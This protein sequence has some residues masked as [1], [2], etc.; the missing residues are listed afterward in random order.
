MNSRTRP[1]PR[2]GP[3]PYSPGPIRFPV[4]T[5]TGETVVVNSELVAEDGRRYRRSS[6]PLYV[7]PIEEDEG[8]GE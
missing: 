6:R 5:I 3:R 7:E 4:K 8:G 1:G 2:R